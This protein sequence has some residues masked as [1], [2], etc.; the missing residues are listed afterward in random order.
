MKNLLS[1]LLVL[2]LFSLQSA[3]Q[4]KFGLR[5][6]G[7]FATW[8][9]DI[10]DLP[11]AE[12]EGMTAAH[13]GPYVQFPLSEKFA[14]EPAIL[15]SVKGASVYIFETEIDDEDIFTYEETSDI[16][17]FYIDIPVLLRFYVIEGF[18]IY[19]GPQLSFHITN[20]AEV[21]YEECFNDMCFSDDEDD[22]VE[23]TGTDFAA[24]AGIGYDFPFGL[25]INVGYDFG[26]SDIDDTGTFE[27]TNE[28]LKV[29][30]GWTF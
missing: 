26:L 3:A 19:A 16:Y 24:V 13:F 21:E 6:G 11:L 1:L 30:L 14:L 5:L 10:E 9:S 12:I 22:D 18:N 2:S 27:T 29:S 8:S 17:L 15:G 20:V 28:V 7:S 4:A 23:V 25:N